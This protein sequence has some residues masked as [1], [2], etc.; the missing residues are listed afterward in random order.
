MSNARAQKRYR[1]P[2]A[3]SPTSERDSDPATRV[4]MLIRHGE[5]PANGDRGV[6]RAGIRNKRSLTVAGWAR[7]GALLELFAPMVGP[8]RPGLFRPRALFASNRRGPAGGSDRELQTLQLLAG[9]LGIDIDLEHGVGEEQQLLDA[10]LATAGP[11][12]VCWKHDHMTTIAAGLREVHPAVPS[13]WP[14]D[15]YD[16]V[17][18]FTSSPEPNAATYQ[19]SQVP[20]L[21][22]P[23][24]SATPIS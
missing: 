16:L 17:W 12:L 5:K 4:I 7:A 19:F 20:E 23:E 3:A 21:L 2:N 24:D 18:V 11:A 15:R 13:A 22:L 8:L 6:T 1:E 9:R 10:L 14:D